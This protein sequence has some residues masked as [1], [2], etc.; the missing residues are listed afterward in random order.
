MRRI[1][2]LR[3]GGED[4]RRCDGEKKAF[5]LPYEAAARAL[6][7][8]SG[9]IAYVGK[10]GYH[11]TKKLAMVASERMENADGSEHRWTV[12][13]VR[14]LTSEMVI[15]EG[16]TIGDMTYLCNMAYA[17]FYPKVLK[18]EEAC[19]RY[20]LAMARDPD[21]YDGLPFCRWTAD[22]IGKGVTIDWEK[23]E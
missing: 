14:Q 3:K 22:L 6:M 10:H 2:V 13:E 15:P 4:D 8:A 21:G 5:A 12:D 11:F 20:A 18:T 7:G 23:L 16:M 19:A 17:D 1:F 9:Y